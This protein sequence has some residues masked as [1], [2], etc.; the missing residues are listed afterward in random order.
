MTYTLNVMYPNILSLKQTELLPFIKE[1]KKEFYLVG[2]TAIALHIGHRRSIDFDLFI[3]KN[4]NSKKIKEKIYKT[5]YK[6][7]IIHEEGDQ[8]HIRV[9]EVK[10]T[11]FHFGFEIP[12]VINFSNNITIPTLLDLAAMKAFAI[13]QRAKWKDYVDMYFIMKGHHTLNEI[14]LR[15]NELFS[16]MFSAKLLRQQLSYFNDID[17]SEE[18]EFMDGFGVSEETVKNYLIDIATSLF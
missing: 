14:S 6:K 12:H 5:S 1:F 16:G 13:G 3:H 9:N 17:Y 8:L 18:V 15:A 7:E 4:F 10:I 2:D 11:F